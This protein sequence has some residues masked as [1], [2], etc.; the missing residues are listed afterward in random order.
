VAGEEEFFR[1]DSKSAYRTTRW[2]TYQR[3]RT[4]AR[5]SAGIEQLLTN[6]ETGQMSR[7]ELIAILSVLAVGLPEASKTVPAIAPVE[8]LNHVTLFVKNVD[9]SVQFYRELFGMPLLTVQAPGVNLSAGTGFLGIYPEQGQGTGIN[10]FCFGLDNFD[11]DRVLNKLSNHGVQ[12][13]I[14]LRG[15]TKELHFTDPDNIHVQLQDVS[16]NGGVGPLGNRTPK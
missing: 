4:E 8:Q 14:R 9:K 2:A 7:R 16:Y 6:Y 15:D 11:A 13:R 12:A 5:M 10:H 1:Q 3:R